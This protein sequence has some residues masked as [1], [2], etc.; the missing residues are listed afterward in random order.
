M[1]S[2]ILNPARRLADDERGS[3]A[4]LFGLMFMT[5]MFLV[6]IAIDV[7]RAVHTDQRLTAAI[8]AAAL[9]AGRNLIDGKLNDDEIR[10]NAIQILKQNFEG[11]GK[12]FG[13]LQDIDVT[14]DRATGAVRIETSAVMPATITA[15]AGYDTYTIGGKAAALFEQKDIEL[16]LALDLTGSMCAPCTKIND[17]KD[18]VFDLMDIMLPVGGTPNKVRLALA[19]YAAGVNSGPYHGTVTGGIGAH[20]CTF[21]RAASDPVTDAVPAAGSYLLGQTVG[22]GPRC[23]A[24]AE[25]VPLTKE[26]SVIWDNNVRDYTTGGSTAGHLGIQWASYLLSDKWSGVFGTDIAPYKDGKTVKAVVLMT[27]GVFNTVAGTN[28]GDVSP[29]ATESANRAR[30][31]CNELRNE[32]D[33]IVFSVG[34]MLDDIAN[35]T[36]RANAEQVLRD[37]AGSASNFYRAENGEMLR[38]AFRGIAQQLNNL[39]LTQ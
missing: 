35:N 28:G 19:P 11:A 22:G 16:A 5:F 34:F 15:I 13:E 25:V 7:G 33:V 9:S 32:R 31:I 12:T 39:R 18:A 1:T 23:P 10:E 36:A 6:G 37:C 3:I 14:L 21:E 8:D 4:I 20:K 30:A 38:Q 24:S 17:L 27:D 29:R 26:R 2:A